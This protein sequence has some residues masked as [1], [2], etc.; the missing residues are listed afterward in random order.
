MHV[1]G[2][3]LHE[4]GM[5]EGPDIIRSLEILGWGGSDGFDFH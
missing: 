3:R 1:P 5:P 4:L 2:V